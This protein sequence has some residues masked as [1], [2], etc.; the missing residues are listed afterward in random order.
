M[1]PLLIAA[2]G[3][4]L[5]SEAR[6]ACP[7]RASWPGADWPDRIAA[8]ATSRA[9]EIS[10]LEK[11]AF[12]LVGA[13][14]D[15]VGIRTDS[16]VIIQG[17]SVVYEKY[18]RGWDA[19]KKHLMWSSS[20]SL[21]E[22]LAGVA[23]NEGLLSVVDSICKYVSGLPA[24]SCDITVEHLLEMSSGLDWKEVY[25]NESNQQSSVLAMLYGQG[26]SDMG[27]FTGSHHRRA[28][29]G[30]TWN[31]STGETTLLARVLDAVLRPKHGERYPWPALFDV[32]GARRVAFER[33]PKGTFVGGSYWYAT[34]REAARLGY[35]YLNDGCWNGTRLVPEG[36]VHT[37][38]TPNPTFVSGTRLNADPT[39]VYG[40]LWWLNAAVPTANIPVPYPD[41]PTDM[42]TTIGHWGQ[43]VTVIPSLDLL[44]VRL[45]DDRDASAL[46]FNQF[47][48][49]SIAV[50]RAP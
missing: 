17:G 33:D 38:T 1:R 8:T 26:H 14:A 28:A 43:T 29:P 31:Y 19:T 46:D 30:T 23:V 32:I 24:E 37:S 48:K 20:K 47:L 40:R 16:V 4:S 50:G 10:A 41:V 27:V 42:Y 36:W 5:A 49:L 3:L 11:Y 15:R 22:V 7:A 45:A 34:P 21:T 6:A 18:A 2:V 13:D 12:T 44:V 39:D 25:E 35:L 9:A